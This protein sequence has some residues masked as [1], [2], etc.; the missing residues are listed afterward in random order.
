MRDTCDNVA[1]LSCRRGRAGESTAQ[2]G[3]FGGCAFVSTWAAMY[4]KLDI[5]MAAQGRA[6][7]CQSVCRAV[8]KQIGVE[9]EGEREG[10]VVDGMR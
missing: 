1:L 9:R 2:A 10:G 4:A 3:F 5:E 7:V 6:A 8:G